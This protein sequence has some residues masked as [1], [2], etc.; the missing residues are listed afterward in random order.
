MPCIDPSKHPNC[1]DASRRLGR[2]GDQMAR[3]CRGE[4]VSDPHQELWTADHRS[5]NPPR[6]VPPPRRLEFCLGEDSCKT[7]LENPRESAAILVA[8]PW[9]SMFFLISSTN[10]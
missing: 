10:G 6:A 7:E 5:A 4:F 9:L 8:F 3:G 2:A 1:N